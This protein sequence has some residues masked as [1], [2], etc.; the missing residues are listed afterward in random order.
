MTTSTITRADDRTAVLERFGLAGKYDTGVVKHQTALFDKDGWLLEDPDT[1]DAYPLPRVGGEHFR[2]RLVI[3]WFEDGSHWVRTTHWQVL[4]PSTLK[5][6]ERRPLLTDPDTWVTRDGRVLQIASMDPGHAGRTVE[7][8][9][10]HAPSV[11]RA[12]TNEAF[13]V[14]A[15]HDGGDLTQSVL[16]R[17]A[18]QLEATDPKDAVKW[19][20][21][22]LAA[23]LTNLRERAAAA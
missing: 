17:E 14:A 7:W 15:F 10:R 18:W 8:L 13:Q 5:V 2:E 9:Y 23:K 12:A 11:L 20:E 1:G 3:S 21:T 4:D 19:M 16:D 22:Y 6:P